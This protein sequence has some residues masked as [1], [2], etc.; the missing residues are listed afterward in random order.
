MCDAVNRRD[1]VNLSC[2]GSLRLFTF[3]GK[4]FPLSSDRADDFLMTVLRELRSQ[5]SHQAVQTKW[6]M[7][8]FSGTSE[9]GTGVSSCP[10]TCSAAG[11]HMCYTHSR[12]DLK[13]GQEALTGLSAGERGRHQPERSTWN[14]IKTQQ[15][16]KVC[17]N[18]TAPSSDTKQI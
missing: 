1:T 15:L 18:L 11:S 2:A 6:T 17:T 14:G 5:F 4:A 9:G 8:I 16:S 13:H 7:N 10:S 12:A 3:L